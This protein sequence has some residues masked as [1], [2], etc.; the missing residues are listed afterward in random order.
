MLLVMWYG[1][2]FLCLYVKVATFVAMPDIK[3]ATAH[4]LKLAVFISTKESAKGLS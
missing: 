4:H 2:L 1:K 3:G